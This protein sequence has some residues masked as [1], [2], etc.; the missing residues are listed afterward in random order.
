MGTGQTPV[1]GIVVGLSSPAYSPN[2]CKQIG[3]AAGAVARSSTN[4]R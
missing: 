2:Q 1:D 3:I 4:H